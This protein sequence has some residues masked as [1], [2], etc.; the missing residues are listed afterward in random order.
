M[1]FPEFTT[2]FPPPSILLI[3]E[4]LPPWKENLGSH[5]EAAYIRSKLIDVVHLL[6]VVFNN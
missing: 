4:S 2:S 1:L 5:K 6:C 3:L